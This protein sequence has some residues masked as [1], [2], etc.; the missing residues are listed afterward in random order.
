M[1]K[2]KV[3]NGCGKDLTPYKRIDGFVYCKTCSG[4]FVKAKVTKV[5]PIKVNGSTICSDCNKPKP[6]ANKSRKLCFD[7][8]GKFKKAR[9]KE[10]SDR[11]K[12]LK[13]ESITQVKLDQVTSWLVRTLYPPKCPHCKI[14]LE[15]KTSNCGHFV[16]RTK[17]ATRLSLMNLCAVDRNCNF[18]VPEHV[19]SIGKFLDTIWGK[20]TA[21]KQ[22]LIAK[23]KLKL[24]PFD[25]REIY[26]V[27][28]VALEKAS[29][30]NQ[31]QKYELLK[32]TQLKY[33]AI[34]NPLIK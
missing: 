20:G 19:W 29:G 31:D 2:T 18:Y 8:F 5:P 1:K 17:Q 26:L 3:C 34:V 25:R 33:E 16:S 28:Q 9:N 13:R 22:I 15:Y 10:R 7:C 12:K 30:L 11:R 14:D 21:D 4:K 27:Y 24:S 32:E 6:Y 23:K